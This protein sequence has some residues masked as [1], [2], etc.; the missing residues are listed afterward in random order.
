MSTIN[1][2][3]LNAKAWMIYQTYQAV[4]AGQSMG[5]IEELEEQF[6]AVA[7][8]LGVPMEEL[9]SNLEEEHEGMFAYNGT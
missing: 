4:I 3:E 1:T 5:T 2:K 9:W 6:D 7:K 8:K